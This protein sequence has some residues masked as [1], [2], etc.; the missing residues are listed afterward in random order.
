MKAMKNIPRLIMF[1]VLTLIAIVFVIP[2]FYSVFNSFKSQKEILSTTMT[3]FPRNSLAYTHTAYTYPCPV[4]H[5]LQV[6]VHECVVNIPRN[7]PIWVY[8][9]AW[10]NSSTEAGK[11]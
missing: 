2:I 10:T 3:F 7:F 4:R 6:P 8:R 11:F 1:A 5:S 9:P